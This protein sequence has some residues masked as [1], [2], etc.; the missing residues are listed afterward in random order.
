M[1]AIFMKM[2]DFKAGGISELFVQGGFVFTVIFCQTPK[3]LT[4]GYSAA[5]L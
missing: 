3:D 2:R 5:Y 4:A 1:P